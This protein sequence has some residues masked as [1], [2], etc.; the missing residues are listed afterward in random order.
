VE[1]TG[2]WEDNLAASDFALQ[3]GIGRAMSCRVSTG[4]ETKGFA[5]LIKAPRVVRSFVP[6]KGETIR[7]RDE[8]GKEIWSHGDEMQCSI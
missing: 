3:A 4:N 8:S 1:F 7:V 2:Y 6:L 5:L